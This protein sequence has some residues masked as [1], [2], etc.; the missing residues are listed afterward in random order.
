MV[1]CVRRGP[2]GIWSRS[3]V[4]PVIYQVCHGPM[5]KARVGRGSFGPWGG[6]PL[7]ET[8]S[9]TVV[10]RALQPAA[11]PLVYVDLDGVPH[12]MGRLWAKGISNYRVLRYA[13]V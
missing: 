10:R 6:V 2:E 5:F 1:N 4:H 12:V 7:G 3:I 11:A 13:K 8:S 9:T